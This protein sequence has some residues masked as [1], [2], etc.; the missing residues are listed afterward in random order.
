MDA[1]HKLLNERLD[2]IDKW[3]S[4]GNGEALYQILSGSLRG[5]DDGTGKGQVTMNLRPIA[6]PRTC[7]IGHTGMMHNQTQTAQYPDVEASSAKSSHYRGHTQQAT[8]YLKAADR[9]GWNQT[10]MGWAAKGLPVA[11]KKG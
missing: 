6:F 4:E 3:L 8:S 2:Q 11:A 7:T 1:A 9:I 5:P 10:T